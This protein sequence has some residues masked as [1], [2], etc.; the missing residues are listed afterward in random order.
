LSKEYAHTQAAHDVSSAHK[1]ASTDEGQKILAD[2]LFG[3]SVPALKADA[4]YDRM[5][6]GGDGSFEAGEKLQRRFLHAATHGSGAKSAADIQ[7]DLT[8]E[9]GSSVEDVQKALKVRTMEQMSALSPD[10]AMDRSRTSSVLDEAGAALGAGI[11]T[12]D[13]ASATV[14]DQNAVRQND[15]FQMMVKGFGGNEQAAADFLDSYSQLKGPAKAHDVDAQKQLDQKEN[16]MFNNFKTNDVNYRRRGSLADAAV[17]SNTSRS[18]LASH[19]IVG[20]D[21]NGDYAAAS[22]EQSGFVT[23]MQSAASGID[24]QNKAVDRLFEI[25]EGSAKQREDNYKRRRKINKTV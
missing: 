7:L 3:T 22:I 2:A 6:S 11:G 18:T 20:F 17:L 10:E 1:L 25:D 15:A 16:E 21:A 13:W 14:D 4:D 5:V 9:S 12:G 24:T 8:K 19:E 23:D